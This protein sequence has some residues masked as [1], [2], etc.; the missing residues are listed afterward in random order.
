MSAERTPYYKVKHTRASRAQLAPAR[1]ALAMVHTL[2]EDFAAEVATLC[3]Q[4][5]S[6][7]E[8]SDFLDHLVPSV[9][10]AGAPLKGRSKTM[11]DTSGPGSRRSKHTT[12]ASNPGRGPPS[13]CCRPSTPTNTTT[14]WS[15]VQL[16]PSGTCCAPSPA[17]SAASTEPPGRSSLEWWRR[18]DQIGGP[19]GNAVG[20]L[21]RALFH[22]RPQQTTPT[23]LGSPRAVRRHRR[24]TYRAIES[25]ARGRAEP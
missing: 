24:C 3:E 10:A 20:P 6:P 13:G 14:V 23:G 1:Q 7:S 4:T 12:R 15:A 16:A 11:A 22:V 18:S 25:G 8:W 2:A 17:T 19:R 5:V 21:A 9:D